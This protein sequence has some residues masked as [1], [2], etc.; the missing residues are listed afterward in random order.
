M[1]SGAL[2][3]EQHR[4]T[5][6]VEGDDLVGRAGR[7]AMRCSEHEIGAD[8]RAAAEVSARTDDGDDGSSDAFV[9]LNCVANNGIRRHGRDDGSEG[10]GGEK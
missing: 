4:L 2:D 9:A 1:C 8:H 5:L 6:G 3:I 7:N 10:A